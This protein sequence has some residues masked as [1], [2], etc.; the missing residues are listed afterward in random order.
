MIMAE[1][2]NW[3]GR[4]EIGHR[5]RPRRAGREAKVLPLFDPSTGS[6]RDTQHPS[7]GAAGASRQAAQRALPSSPRRG[8]EE[9]LIAAVADML[10]ALRPY[11]RQRPGLEAML[12]KLRT[13]HCRELGSDGA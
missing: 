1:R 10:R 11:S 5:A 8:E 13:E 7:P 9:A 3:G 12:R 2:L 4:I 6:G